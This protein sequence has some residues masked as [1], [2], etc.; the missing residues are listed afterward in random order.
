MREKAKPWTEQ[1]Y[2]MGTQAD[3]GE[4]S[5]AAG[6]TSKKRILQLKPETVEIGNNVA[7]GTIGD[8][9]SG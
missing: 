3:K 1:L 7:V 9:D 6:S 2:R 8:F 5:W 4:S